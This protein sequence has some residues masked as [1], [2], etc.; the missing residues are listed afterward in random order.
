[1]YKVA[2]CMWYVLYVCGV[3]TMYMVCTLY[4]VYTIYV[5]CTLCTC[6][7]H[8]TKN[9]TVTEWP[10]RP[11]NKLFSNTMCPVFENNYAFDNDNEA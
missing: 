11:T 8:M 10:L 2:L 6:C 9:S 4:G 5:T 1:M 3:Y 7:V